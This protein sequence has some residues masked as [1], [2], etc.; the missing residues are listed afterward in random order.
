MPYSISVS[1]HFADEVISGGQV[2]LFNVSGGCKVEKTL[3]TLIPLCYPSYSL[4]SHDDRDY[5]ENWSLLSPRDNSTMDHW[6]GTDP[7]FNPWLYHT[8]LELDGVPMWGL[9]DVYSGGGYLAEFGSKARYAREVTDYLIQTRWL[10][11]H[12]R[13]LFIEFN[14]YNGFTNMFSVFTLMVEFSPGGGVL[15]F[16]VIRTLKL[17]NYVGVAAIFRLALEIGFVLFI[18]YYLVLESLKMHRL[19]KAYFTNFW[20]VLE[21][22]NIAGAIASFVLYGMHYTFTRLTLEKFHRNPGIQYYTHSVGHPRY[23][24]E[25]I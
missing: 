9:L 1:M 22:V 15:L 5:S 12:S 17:Y 25:P 3:Q 11:R 8:S 19:K 18:L 20:N 14:L 23:S 4:S 7:D 16:P 13:A 2:I 6:N 10:E 24:L 21:L